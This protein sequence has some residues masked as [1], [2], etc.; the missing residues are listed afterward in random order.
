MAQPNLSYWE[1]NS[2]IGRPDLLII[3]SGIVGLTAALEY[4]RHFPS[5]KILVVEKSPIAAG[6]STRNAGFA[7]FGSISEILADLE[8][9]DEQT[10]IDL[11]K[12]RWEGLARL[13]KLVGDENMDY[14]P[15]GNFEIFRDG[16]NTLFEKCHAAIPQLNELMETAIGQ[17][18]VFK[19]QPNAIQHQGL[20][21]TQ[22]LIWNKSEGMIHTG[23]M[24]RK[25]IDLARQR[26]ILILNGVTVENL[27]TENSQVVAKLNNDWEIKAT[28]AIVATNGFAHQLLPDIPVRP[29]RNLVL[30]TQPII[31]LKIKGAFHCDAGYFYF[32][33]IDNRILLGGGR[34]LDA[35][36]EETDEFGQNKII[37]TALIKFLKEVILP[38][39]S[40]TI[41]RWW[42][43][44]LGVGEQKKPII[45]KQNDRLVVAAR[46][47]G[48]GVAIGSSVG[49][50]AVEKLI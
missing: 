30:V 42:S 21:Q 16:D 24:M 23:K 28:H 38:Q 43:G 11:I 48:M 49:V 32:R 34:H 10:V 1:Q 14:Q 12:S 27:V 35:I 31:G 4:R 25:L 3:G 6:G 20:G 41:D 45:E 22:H 15:T 40:H 39:R 2:F 13:R 17:K 19:E 50:S 46:M 29:A 9:H 37:K 36:N 44:I 26:N 7:C 5:A 33:N 8:N 47:G 18:Y